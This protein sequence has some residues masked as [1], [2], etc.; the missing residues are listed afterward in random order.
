MLRR[1]LIKAVPLAIAFSPLLV[2]AQPRLGLRTFRDPGC[3]CCLGWVRHIEQAGFD[4][5]VED[6]ARTDP[7][8]GRSGA[9]AALIGCHTALHGRFG[10]EGHVPA[11]AV[12]R[13]LADPGPWVGL[14]VRGMPV[15]SPGMEV[16]GVAA[17][18]YEIF[19]FDGSGW[20][21]PYIQARG[22]MIM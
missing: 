20:W 2:R 6:R 13:F 21:E 8:R 5:S 16:A 12:K 1:N 17:E 18:T 15:G 4:V 7:G 14:A 11:A 10:F 9:P 22:S 19:R 3:E